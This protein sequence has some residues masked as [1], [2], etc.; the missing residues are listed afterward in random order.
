MNNLT[1]F[2]TWEDFNT[3][4]LYACRDKKLAVTF[5]AGKD[6]SVCLYLLNSVKKKYNLF[7][8]G[9]LYAF[10]EHRYSTEFNKKLTGFWNREGVNINIIKPEE[11]D[12]ILEQTDNPCRPCQ[13]VR[14][15]ALFRLFKV[16]GY[17]V[18][19]TVLVSGHSLWDLAG[20]AVNRTVAAEVADSS[21][22]AES[23]S[24]ERL[25]EISQ[26]FYPFFTMP[27]GYS[28]YRPMLSLNQNEIENICKA[29]T[30]PVIESSCRYS[31][32]RPKNLLGEYFKQFGYEF[33]Y[34]KVL[35]FAKKHHKIAELDKIKNL[36]QKEY[37]S[38][39][40]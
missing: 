28:V 6:S 2:K 22:L 23:T 30:I 27:E 12:S 38:K 4:Y 29:K 11:D 7:L 9:F 13:N 20:Y 21:K 31:E 10:P 26:R 1:A 5:S 35:M 19:E 16:S 37:L 32:S 25:I 14:K 24:E 39:H 15:K 33:S 8:E 34:K 40:F 3:E 18:S 17:K 36:T